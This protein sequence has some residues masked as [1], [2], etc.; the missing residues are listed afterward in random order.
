LKKILKGNKTKFNEKLQSAQKIEQ[1]LTIELEKEKEKNKALLEKRENIVAS[2]NSKQ[3]VPDV[4][5]TQT[6]KS[7]NSASQEVVKETAKK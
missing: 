2:G 7:S 6:K 5:K 4:Q 3:I 1:A